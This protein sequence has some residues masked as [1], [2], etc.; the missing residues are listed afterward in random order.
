MIVRKPEQK[1]KLFITI[2]LSRKLNEYT[3][4]ERRQEVAESSDEG[5]SENTS[6]DEQETRRNSRF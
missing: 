1:V 6:D 3:K 2:L 5:E 4:L